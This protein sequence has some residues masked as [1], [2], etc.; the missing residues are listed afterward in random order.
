MGALA[1]LLKIGQMTDKL[2]EGSVLAAGEVS[3]NVIEVNSGFGIHVSAWPSDCASWACRFPPQL[4]LIG[5]MYEGSGGIVALA[6]RG[7][8]SLFWGVKRREEGRQRLRLR[9]QQCDRRS[10]Q[11]LSHVYSIE[12]AQLG[13]KRRHLIFGARFHHC[14]A[15]LAV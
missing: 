13:C 1:V 15:L 11:T 8:C 5:K 7:H 12:V 4:L 3:T 2:F 14:C 10:Q 9:K 6:G